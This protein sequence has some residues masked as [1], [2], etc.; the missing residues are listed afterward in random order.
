MREV[1]RLSSIE[2][3]TALEDAKMASS[4]FQLPDEL[5]LNTLAQAF[6]CRDAQIR[7]L[8]TLLHVKSHGVS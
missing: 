1:I 3:W 5:I 8:A 4:L 2:G 6:P 7:A